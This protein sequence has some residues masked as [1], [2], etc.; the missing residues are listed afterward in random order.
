[1]NPEIIDTGDGSHSLFLPE[2]NETYHSRK[3][4]L[5]ESLYVYIE[6]GLALQ[7]KTQISILEFGFGTGLNALLAWEFAR[8]NDLNLHYYTAELYPLDL[9]LALAL[10]YGAADKARYES[11][12]RANWGEWIPLDKQFSLYKHKGRFLDHSVSDVDLIF[13]DAFAPSKQPEVWSLEYLQKAWDALAPSGQLVTYC[14]QGQFKRD[15]KS[16]GFEI[17]TLAGPPGKQEMVRATRV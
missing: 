17:E 7:S 8:K 2:L 11:L 13:Y 4:A 10:N 3:G 12:H 15:L 16:I 1:M 9:E 5:T 14:A 6:Q